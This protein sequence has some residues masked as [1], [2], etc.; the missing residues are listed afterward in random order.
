[1]GILRTIKQVS[2]ERIDCCG[3]LTVTLG[4]TAEPDIIRHP[5]DIVLALDCSRSMR[6]GRLEHMQAGVFRLIDL[7]ARSTV[8]T[9]RERLGGGTRM[10]VLR[11]DCTAAIETELTD[12]V[13][14][15]RA[16]VEHLTACGAT[17]HGAAFEAAE[18]LF[19]ADSPNEKILLL[20][21]DGQTTA[22]PD[23]VPAAE[24]L[25][26]AGVTIYCIGLNAPEELLN[27]WVSAP[28]ECHRARADAPEELERVF[29]RMG[30]E[31]VHPGAC[32]V[33][34]EEIISPDFTITRMDRPTHGTVRRTGSNTLVWEMEEVGAVPETALLRFEILHVGQSG[35][36]KAVNYGLRYRDRAGNRPEFPSPTVEVD[37][38]APPQ[39]DPACC[40]DP[41]RVGLDPCQQSACV[42]VCGVTPDGLGRVVTVSFTLKNICPGK[43]VAAAVFLTEV[44]RCGQEFSRGL[45]TLTVPAHPG[46]GCRDVRVPCVRFI[47]PEDLNPGHGCEWDSLCSPREF[48]V[49]VMANYIDTDFSC[50]GER[51]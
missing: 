44:G 25:K 6:C 33:S 26:A 29:A 13:P 10:A 9:E 28:A 24:K 27:R 11:F 39:P 14:D 45:Q 48:S 15:L 17:N 50:C 31:L 51:K 7:L 35:G 8:G 20:F 18:E 3:R 23:P 4:L 34:M 2:A 21:T 36:L 41:V 16:A 37:C 22:G 12:R 38:S 1:M 42:E 47:V 19:E 5:A 46:P 43:R 40:P 32:D 30:R 49:R